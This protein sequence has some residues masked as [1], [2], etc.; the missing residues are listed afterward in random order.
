[1]PYAKNG[2]VELYYESFGDR[3]DPALVMVN[4]LGSQ[5]INYRDELIELLVAR[6][7]FVVR[8]DNRD[9][10]L[11]TKLDAHVTDFAA[12]VA[13]RR[14]GTKPD[15]A[16]LLSDM[17]LD[18]VAVMDAVGAERASIFGMSL[19]GMIV[20]QTA[21]DHPE[22]VVSLTS[23]MSTTGDPD[24]GQPTPEAQAALYRKPAASRDEVIAN[25]LADS[26]VFGS[27]QHQE[28]DYIAARAAAAYD[29][30]FHPAGVARQ[31]MA[32]Q[33]SPS[34]SLALRSLSTPTLV[35]H[36]DCDTLIDVSGGRRTAECVPGATLLILEGMGHDL[37]KA[38]W[39]QIIDAVTGLVALSAAS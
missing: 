3:A 37:P 33:A 6:G 35:L 2:D 17:A 29:R 23:V 25:A 22:R 4:G 38:Y 1:M 11:S 8:F 24:V 21:I 16:Y 39:G 15:V 18:T 30:S 31:L 32:A 9:V 28:P 10:G 5:C 12:F 14:A 36:G 13:A 7:L 27:P 34:R 20:Q 26:L 19:G